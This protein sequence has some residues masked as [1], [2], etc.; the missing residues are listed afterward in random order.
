MTPDLPY[1][2]VIGYPIEHSRSP[3]IHRRWIEALGL[4]ARYEAQLVPTGEL[5]D[6]FARRRGDPFWRGCNVTMPHKEAVLALLDRLE[7]AAAAIGAVNTIFRDE[8]GRLVGRNTDVHGIRQ[9]LAGTRRPHRAVLVGAGGA[10]RAAAFALAQW[11]VEEVHIMA[12]RPEQAERLAADL[13]P[14]ATTGTFGPAPPADLLI[15]ATPIGMDGGEEW[16]VA[17]D[18]LPGHAITFDMIYA[19]AWTPLRL[20]AER[21]GLRTLGGAP[22]LLFQAAEAFTSFFGKAAPS[23]T[24]GTLGSEL[25]R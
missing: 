19:P 4:K 21:Q 18:R 2:E 25:A 23:D 9:A 3:L 10:A 13:F 11:G 14:A 7:G 1:A 17:L 22:M 5:R 15:N 12:R 8:E 6:Y 20:A 16:P 24:Y